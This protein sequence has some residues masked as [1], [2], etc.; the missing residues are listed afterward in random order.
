[1]RLY[2]GS[3]GFFLSSERF[4]AMAKFLSQVYTV[5]RGSV[6]GV[7][8]TANKYHA[9]IARARVAPVQPNTNPQAWSK[10][11]FGAAIT[12]WEAI[13]KANRD[14]WI[15]YA[16]TVVRSGPLGN[17]SPSGRMLAIAQYQFT[18]FYRTRVGDVFTGGASMDAP[19]LPGALAF[20]SPETVPLV[21][22]GIGFRFQCVNNNAEA[23]VLICTRSPKMADQ[24]YFYK[25]PFQS[26]TAAFVDI[27]DAALEGVN[28]TG[29]IDG[30]VYFVRAM[31]V[32][33]AVERRISVPVI[34][35]VEATETT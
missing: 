34:L 23:V 22:P 32:T 3:W 27:A 16:S 15:A 33:K 4:D 1:M 18:K 28:F 9:L 11:A 7:T 24:K 2:A 12:A 20:A 30:G 14:L 10:A 31:I 8:Y 26:D 6:G 13:T 17:Y 5:I 25:G 21:A 19:T 35:R 29:L